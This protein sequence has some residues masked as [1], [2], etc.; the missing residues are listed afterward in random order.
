M[1]RTLRIIQRARADVDDIFNWLVRRS[2]QGAIAWYFAFNRA[3]N[4]ILLSP[5]TFA[6]A[7]ESLPLRRELRQ[8]LFKT[9]RGRSYRI[10]FEVFETE[11][12]VLRVR[13]P[14]QKPLQRR[15]VPNE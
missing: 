6:P 4:Q 14:G 11:I 3:S 15:D 13:G 9:R 2:I 1:S 5:E 8:A 10:V 12:I 7:P